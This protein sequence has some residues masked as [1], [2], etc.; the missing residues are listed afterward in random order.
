MAGAPTQ[1]EA[2]AF[3]T[4]MKNSRTLPYNWSIAQGETIDHTRLLN[5][6][7]YPA[8]LVPSNDYDTDY[9]IKQQI[10]DVDGMI[11]PS[12]PMPWTERD[13]DY[14]KNRRDAEE[15]AAYMD[16]V[17]R[18]FPINDPANREMFK[19]ILP[20]YFSA[21]KQVLQ[22]QINLSAKYANLRLFGPEN[23]EDLILQYEVETGR[24]KLPQGPFHDP[25]KWMENEAGITARDNED[26]YN[27][28]ITDLNRET[29]ER[30]L[31]NPFS[32]LTPQ[33]APWGPNS[34]NMADQVGDPRFR[35]LGPPGALVPQNENYAHNYFGSTLGRISRM[36]GWSNADKTVQKSAAYHNA[37]PSVGASYTY[38]TEANQP[39]VTA[40]YNNVGT[41]YGAGGGVRINNRQAEYAAMN[42][43]AP[44]VAA[45][46]PANVP[47]AAGGANNNNLINL[48]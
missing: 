43:N 33:N 12:R 24:V 42:G 20:G 15:Y 7:V 3:G 17:S 22:E 39:Y 2:S 28:K 40:R 30:G 16:W 8:R 23:E 11:S 18:K 6:N 41:T 25:I 4:K 38:Q 27:R 10:T 35:A 31:F 46:G 14:L 29:Y 26:E 9:M 21:R 19:R 36:F 13:I 48:G 45:P 32:F 44:N 5:S 1:K 34:Y 37:L 47:P